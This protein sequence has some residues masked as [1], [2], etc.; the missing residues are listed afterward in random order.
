MVSFIDQHRDAYGVEPICA[1]LPIEAVVVDF[2][3][4]CGSKFPGLPES[5]T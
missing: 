3:L 1:Q 2:C 5:Q 4:R